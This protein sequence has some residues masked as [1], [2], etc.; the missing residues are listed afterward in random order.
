MKK[1]SGLKNESKVQKL[2]VSGSSAL[3]V[4]NPAGIRIARKNK[5]NKFT[6]VKKGYPDLSEIPSENF[7]NLSEA[8]ILNINEL[9]G[10]I[11]SGQLIRPKYDSK[12]LKKSID[13]EIFELIPQTKVELP[14]TVLR[15][16]YNEVT[17][18]VNDLTIE[19]QLLTTDILNLNS[20]ISELEIET[21]T[22]RI[23]ADNEK[24][25]ANVSEQQ[26]TVANKQVAETTIDLQNAIQN[27]INEAIQRVSLTARNE[28]LYQENE[29]LR[30]QLF[31]LAAQTAEGGISG[32]SKNFTVTVQQNENSPSYDMKD[33]TT[34][35]RAK[36]T[37][38]QEKCV[39][40]I[41]VSNV[42]AT[43]KITKINFNYISG[44]NIFDVRNPTQLEST[45]V[46]SEST[47]NFK[48][49]FN[50]GLKDS[51]PTAWYQKARDYNG[52]FE[53]VVKF[54]DGT[55]DKVTLSGR[56]RKNKKGD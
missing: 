49:K 37:G 17:Q 44:N 48:L 47:I 35:K 27:S 54:D 6:A 29:N 50:S 46:N 16:F 41:D 38:W 26:A 33:T 51:K 23:E 55:T 15:S 12:E 42:S 13:T 30:E 53:V 10:G 14:D 34:R 22:L 11:V 31:G 32:T 7:G 1:E 52:Q 36:T 45:T 20:T 5:S 21:E 25:K 18:S 4:K 9:D 19:V 8:G 39:V 40:S 28:A 43:L 24:L 56:V 3:A 2:M